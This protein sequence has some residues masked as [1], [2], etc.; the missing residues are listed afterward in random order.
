MEPAMRPNQ[1]DPGHRLRQVLV[2]IGCVLMVAV[3]RLIDDFYGLDIRVGFV[4]ILPIVLAA[5]YAGRGSGY[6]I[7]GLSTAARISYYIFDLNPEKLMLVGLNTAI[8]FAVFFSAALLVSKLKSAQAGLEHTVAA[9]TAA[10]EAKIEENERTAEFLRENERQLQA[11][12]D[13]ML[14]GLHIVDL[15][16][17]RVVAA[18]PA[19][20]RML[21]YTREEMLALSVHDFHPAGEQA[22]VMQGLE[23]LRRGEAH[24]VDDALC[25][26][27]DGTVFPVDLSTS[28]LVYRGRPCALAIFR[29]VTERHRAGEALRQSEANYRAI[30]NADNDALFVHDYETGEVLDFNQKAADI[31]GFTPRRGGRAECAFPG[32]PPNRRTRTR[33]GWSGSAGPPPRGPGPSSGWPGPA[34]AAASGWR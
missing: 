31:Y 7:A 12:F 28:P 14:G 32:E 23:R 10:L 27:K 13:T 9:R 19:M 25:V 20:G 16:T 21:G 8:T 26:R 17:W 29:D 1:E 22:K 4:Y 34:T 15:E 30:F 2:V 18:N 11:V 5:W 33:T 3:I 24:V 6:I